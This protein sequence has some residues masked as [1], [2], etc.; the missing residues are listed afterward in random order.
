MIALLEQSMYLTM[1][2]LW[3]YRLL[4]I[5]SPAHAWPLQLIR[6]LPPAYDLPMRTSSTFEMAHCGIF[7]GIDGLSTIA[8]TTAHLRE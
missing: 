6:S 8:V 5:A 2:R 1:L 4:K 3:C 7:R